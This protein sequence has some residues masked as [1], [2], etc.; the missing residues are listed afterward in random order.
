MRYYFNRNTNDDFTTSNV[1]DTVI[2]V[3]RNWYMNSF[4]KRL[5]KI[6]TVASLLNV[7]VH[8]E[9]IHSGY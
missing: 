9:L 8:I 7:L 2:R 3:I 1:F 6:Y 4:I 5:Y